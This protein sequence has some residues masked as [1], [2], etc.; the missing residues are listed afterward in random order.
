MWYTA[1]HWNDLTLVVRSLTPTSLTDHQVYFYTLPALDAV[2]SNIIKPIRNVYTLAIDHEHMLRPP[3]PP[4]IDITQC[5]PIDFC[6]SKRS[7][8]ALYSL[9]ERLF[10]QRVSCPAKCWD[11]KLSVRN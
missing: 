1:F 10:Y 9:R 4:G 7:S 3:A 8:I 6:V 11:Q 5:E 2:P